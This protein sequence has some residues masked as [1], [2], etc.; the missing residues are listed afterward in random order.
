MQIQFALKA[1]MM[2]CLDYCTAPQD[3]PEEQEKSV[4]TTLRWAASCKKEY[5]KLV[6][7]CKYD[8]R[9]LLFA[10]IQG[11]ASKELRRV[12]AEALSAIGF[13]GY[14]YG[15]WPVDENGVLMTDILEYTAGLMPEGSVKYAMGMGRPEEVAALA[16]MGYNLFDCVIPT[17][18]ARRHRLYVFAQNPKDLS[19]SDLMDKSFYRHVYIMDEKYAADKAALSEFCPCP[20]CRRHSRAY[21]RHLFKTGDPLAQRYATIHNLTFYSTLMKALRGEL[22]D[23]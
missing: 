15:G 2:V 12:C 6:K 17:R 11:G 14:G 19:R 23:E 3:G 4:E 8:S 7:S 9:P 13:D 10:V 16:A 20:L 21:L 1:D 5:E 18:E 22:H